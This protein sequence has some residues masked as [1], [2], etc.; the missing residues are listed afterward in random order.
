MKNVT[1]DILHYNNKNNTDI[2][3]DYFPYFTYSLNIYKSH[4]F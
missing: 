3:I 1:V 4:N 2:D